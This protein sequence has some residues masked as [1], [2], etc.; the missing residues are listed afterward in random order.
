METRALAGQPHSRRACPH[1][2]GADVWRVC[3]T[4]RHALNSRKLVPPQRAFLGGYM[5]LRRAIA[6]SLSLAAVG[7]TPARAQNKVIDVTVEILDRF[8]TAH[9]KEKSE[10]KS[11]EAQIS[12]QDAKIAKF[13][14]C[15]RDWEAAASASG[16]KL[17]GLAAR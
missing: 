16:S 6:L 17:G 9:D 1:Q 12:D 10:T 3:C 4:L 15:K 14:Q 5:R 11:V 7:T 8:F 2:S 13:E